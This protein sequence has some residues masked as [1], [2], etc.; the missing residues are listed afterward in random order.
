MSTLRL[1]FEFKIFVFLNIVTSY[2]PH[3]IKD[4]LKSVGL[5]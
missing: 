2:L 3:K 1:N 5:F 4:A